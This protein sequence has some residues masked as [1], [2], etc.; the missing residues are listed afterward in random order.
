LKPLGD[1]LMVLQSRRGHAQVARLLEELRRA[2]K[3]LPGKYEIAAED[4]LLAKAIKLELAG[5]ALSRAVVRLTEAAGV[6]VTL[7]RKEF[8]TAGLDPDQA[9]TLRV[10]DLELRSVLNLMLEPLGL[11]WQLRG[12]EIHIGPNML[13]PQTTRIYNVKHLLR[14]QADG[15]TYDYEPLCRA[16]RATV[17]TGEWQ[18][19]GGSGTIAGFQGMLVVNHTAAVQNEIREVLE[20]IARLEKKQRADA[21]LPPAEIRELEG[22]ARPPA[23][24]EVTTVLYPLSRTMADPNQANQVQNLVNQLQAQLQGQAAPDTKTAVGLVEQLLKAVEMEQ[25]K[26]HAESERIAK[27]AKTL[28]EILPTS[29]NPKSWKGAGGTGEVHA[30]PDA[31]IV[32]QNAEGHAQVRQVLEKMGFDPVASEQLGLIPR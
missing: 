10:S 20:E 31:I 14:A 27:S 9:V 6:P 18:D 32:R 13:A 11:A 28:M 15:R 17:A 4:P 29:V 1:V 5:M 19:E 26:S 22:D 8:E 24:A 16:L 2:R 23:A 25:Q 21:G 12:K 7:D 3:Q 30:L